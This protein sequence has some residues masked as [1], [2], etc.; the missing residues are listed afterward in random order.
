MRRRPSCIKPTWGGVGQDMG[1]GVCRRIDV[2]FTA[3]IHAAGMLGK[4]VGSAAVEAWSVHR[5]DY[6]S[7]QPRRPR[8][9]IR[10]VLP[11]SPVGKSL[12]Q[13]SC[14]RG[15]N[16]TLCSFFS[17]SHE[18][19]AYA[20]N[21]F[22][23]GLAPLQ[24][25]SSPG[26]AFLVFESFATACSKSSVVGGWVCAAV[27]PPFLPPRHSWARAPRSGPHGAKLNWQK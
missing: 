14:R 3:S 4:G 6:W 5:V 12:Q 10:T 7:G 13:E 26:P 17:F 22:R 2:G 1:E 18:T 11:A 19:P 27:L 8:S 21:T 16:Q 15:R 24:A 20:V 9:R 25:P 23:S